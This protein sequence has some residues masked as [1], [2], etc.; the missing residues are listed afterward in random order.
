[1]SETNETQPA[2]IMCRGVRGATT[3][4]S[5]E[6]ED[7]L[8]ATRELVYILIRANNIRQEDVASAYFTVTPDLDATFPATAARQLGWYDVALICGLEIPVPD[9]L[10]KC[11]RVMIHWNTDK[12][13]QEL[14]HVYLHDAQSLRPDRDTVPPIPIEE[15]EAAYN[16]TLEQIKELM[17]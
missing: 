1:M 17:P 8:A 14:I 11:V 13:Q 6:R 3:A 10:A 2:P 9:S 16:G 4:A 15:I 5:N 7:I 12:S